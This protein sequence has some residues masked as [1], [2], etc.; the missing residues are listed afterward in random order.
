MSCE[1]SSR[2]GRR[3]KINVLCVVCCVVCGVWCVIGKSQGER[4]KE[5]L[6]TVAVYISI[7]VLLIFIDSK[8]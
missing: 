2:R 3:N 5:G 8:L 7:V 6:T 1:V 4:N